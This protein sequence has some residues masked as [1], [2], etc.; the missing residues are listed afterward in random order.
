MVAF[1]LPDAED[2]VEFGGLFVALEIGA[3]AIVPLVVAPGAELSALGDVA[4]VAG[5]N[6]PVQLRVIGEERVWDYENEV[7]RYALVIADSPALSRLARD[8]ARALDI[9]EPSDF[10]IVYGTSE[11]DGEPPRRPAE[12]GDA[13][14][15]ER[16]V[17]YGR[18]VEAELA[19]TDR[20]EPL[21]IAL[22][23]EL[24]EFRFNPALEFAEWFGYTIEP[25]PD[26]V[27][28]FRVTS[29][30]GKVLGG[31][32]AAQIISAW[33]KNPNPSVGGKGKKKSGGGGK[34][35]APKKTPAEKARESAQE[36]IEAF[37]IELERSDASPEEKAAIQ[38]FIDKARS[39]IEDSENPIEIK[40][41]VKELKDNIATYKKEKSK[42]AQLDAK[43]AKTKETLIQNL[44]S[45]NVL[46]GTK[47][48]PTD[49]QKI[50]D[51]YRQEIAGAGSLDEAKAALAAMKRDIAE[52]KV[53]R[54]RELATARQQE[55]AERLAQ[56]AAAK[57][58]AGAGKTRNAAKAAVA[59]SEQMPQTLEEWI[60]YYAALFGADAD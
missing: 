34:A 58:A 18:G 16:L 52:Y 14:I 4:I 60:E 47:Y 33:Q 56:R 24:R 19:L 32:V 42:E 21:A 36:S 2:Y 35:A 12:I 41:I 45:A 51:D 28:G 37:E 8:V 7:Y 27:L 10:A 15:G 38:D 23:D 9:P 30:S 49:I 54:D 26:S 11:A 25:N 53:A 48:N 44:P 13:V 29:P 55:K 39:D 5:A 40:Q 1:T 46:A 59:A 50:I 20:W 3:G 17:V 43:L 22:V 31:T 57:A 6:A